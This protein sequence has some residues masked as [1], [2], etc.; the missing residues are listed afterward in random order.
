MKRGVNMTFTPQGST[1]AGRHIV[2]GRVG[3]CLGLLGFSPS[4]RAS[5]HACTPSHNQFKCRQHLP[6]SVRWHF[7]IWSVSI[8]EIWLSTSGWG[9]GARPLPWCSGVTPQCPNGQSARLPCPLRTPDRRASPCAC[10]D[11]RCDVVIVRAAELRER[12]AGRCGYP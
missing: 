7:E 11:S 9:A 6:V 4:V 12:W 5:E 1:E 2:T 10:T 3:Y 8:F